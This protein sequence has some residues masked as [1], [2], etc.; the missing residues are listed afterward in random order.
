MPLED[1]PNTFWCLIIK[2]EIYQLNL[3]GLA[4]LCSVLFCLEKLD[5][6]VLQTGLSGFAQ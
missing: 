6:L 2:G 5:C 3:K 4:L 1:L